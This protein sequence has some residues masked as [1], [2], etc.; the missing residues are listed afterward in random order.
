VLR[1]T[2]TL[3]P[4]DNTSPHPVAAANV[5]FQ[6]VITQA[7][8]DLPPLTIG[9]TNNHRNPSPVVLGS[10]QLVSTSDMD[11]LALFSHQGRNSGTPS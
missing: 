11:G 6:A 1:V 9:D 2:D 7:Q 3:N 8:N 10:Y 4:A 5:V